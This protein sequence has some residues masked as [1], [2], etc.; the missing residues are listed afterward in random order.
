MSA[1]TEL[2]VSAIHQLL[3][4]AYPDSG[5]CKMIKE[6]ITIVKVKVK[7]KVKHSHYRPGQASKFPGG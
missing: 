3:T 2:F 5:C 7:V 1:V 6:P 4:F